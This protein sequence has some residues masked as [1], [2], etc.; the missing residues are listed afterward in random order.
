[1]SSAVR[2]QHEQ[3]ASKAGD[4]GPLGFPDLDS[5][6]IALDAGEIGVGAWDLTSNRMHWSGKCDSGLSRGAFAGFQNDIHPE[7]LPEVTA[8][9][10]ESLREGKPYH[11]PYRLSPRAREEDHALY[12]NLP[13]LNS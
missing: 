3:V 8:A 7:D 5:I 1:M 6:R 11:V 10:Q 12:D 9:I 2:D 13:G 4:A